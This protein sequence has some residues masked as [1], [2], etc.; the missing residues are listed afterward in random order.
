MLETVIGFL[1]VGV[2]VFVAVSFL[3]AIQ[4]QNAAL[5][6][7]VRGGCVRPPGDAGRDG[8]RFSRAAREAINRF[9]RHHRVTDQEEQALL[10]VRGAM[11]Q[12]TDL[13]GSINPSFYR[14]QWLRPQTERNKPLI[15]S[16]KTYSQSEFD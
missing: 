9:A 15:G 11:E 13:G 10:G 1:T 5:L 7:W 4:P 8:D 3:P 16:K 12:R 2:S 6:R 14:T